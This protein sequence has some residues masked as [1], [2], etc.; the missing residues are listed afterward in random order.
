MLSSDNGN[1]PRARCHW[2]NGNPHAL[3]TAALPANTWT[4]LATRFDGTA[5]R[6]FV[7]GVQVASL[8][9]TVQLAPTTAT[10]QIG[11]D[12]YAGENF[13][14]LIDE[15]RVYNRA[16][17]AAEIQADMGVAIGTPPPPV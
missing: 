5:V 8:A 13:A 10:L 6:L 4:H 3:R 9:Q 16:L 7:N 12:A 15:V 14:G 2:I 1:R 11:G 17:S